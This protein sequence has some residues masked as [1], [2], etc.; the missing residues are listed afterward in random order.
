M[1]FYFLLFEHDVKFIENSF[2]SGHK[3]KKFSGI[4][5]LTAS[6]ALDFPAHSWL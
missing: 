5:D 3:E 2:V 1:R 4:A 6:A